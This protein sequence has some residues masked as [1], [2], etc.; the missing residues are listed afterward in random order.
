[1]EA[2]CALIKFG[3]VV[4]P[5][6][7]LR[8]IHRAWI[9]SVHFNYVGGLNVAAPHLGVLLKNTIVLYQELANGGCHPAILVLMVMDRASLANIPAD[10]QQLK[11]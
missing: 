3:R 9:G 10:C 7:W 11:E 5:V 1:M 2:D 6:H 8:R 4:N